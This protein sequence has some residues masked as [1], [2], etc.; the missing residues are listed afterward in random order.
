MRHHKSCYKCM[1]VV[2]GP[3]PM[4]NGILTSEY[5]LETPPLNY[6]FWEPPSCYLSFSSKGSLTGIQSYWTWHVLECKRGNMDLIFSGDDYLSILVFGF[7]LCF[8]LE[9]GS[10]QFPYRYVPHISKTII[11][12]CANRVPQFHK[13]RYHTPATLYPWV[14]TSHTPKNAYVNEHNEYIVRIVVQI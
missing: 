3:E 11:K 6:A 1:S 2:E 5:K 14:Y 9:L 8:I 12:G 7:L 4:L 10:K 13:D